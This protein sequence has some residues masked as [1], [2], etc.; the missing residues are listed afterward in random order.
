MDCLAAAYRLWE[1]DGSGTG[2]ASVLERE[3]DISL[4]RFEDFAAN[5]ARSWKLDSL[6]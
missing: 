5:L 4:V 1:R 2:D 3:F 6:V